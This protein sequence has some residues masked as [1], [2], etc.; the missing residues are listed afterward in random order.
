MTMPFYNSDL[1]FQ[2]KTGFHIEAVAP[3]VLFV[4]NEH[5][6][7]I[8]TD[9]AMATV[10]PQV[11]GQRSIKE[12]I[13]A[14]MH[15]LTAEE[16]SISLQELFNN[17]IIH[18][19]HFINEQEKSAH[20]FWA[21]A[22]VKGASALDNLSVKNVSVQ[23]IGGL[24]TEQIIKSLAASG[25]KVADTAR[26]KIIVTDDYLRAELEPIASQAAAEGVALLLVKPVGL[27]PTIGPIIH[28]QYGSCL[29]CVQFGIRINHPVEHWLSR[30]QNTS[31]FH[32]PLAIERASEQAVYGLVSA[33]IASLFASQ[34]DRI[35]LKNGMLK[36]DLKSLQSNRYAVVKRPQ[37]PTC[38]DADLMK[39]QAHCPPQL[40]SVPNLHINDGGYRKLTP[41]QT[42]E[43]FKHLINPVCGPIA[44][45]HPMPRR[46][47]GM[48]KVYVA[49]YM[50]CPQDIPR[51][52][53]FDKICAGKGQTDEQARASA[54]CEALE[55]FSGVYQGD[56]ACVRASA[57]ELHAQNKPLFDFNKLQHFSQFQFAQREHINQ[58]THDRRRQVPKQQIIEDKID[59]T[60]AWSLV[61]GKKHY[62]PLNYCYAEAPLS[63]GIEYGI[64]N[65]NGAAAGNCLEE[66]ILQGFLELVER[67][68]TA[69]W[70]Y[71]RI[72]LPGIDLASFNDPYFERLIREYASLGWNCWVLDLTHD[73]GINVCAA[74]AHQA[75]ENRW[76][77]GFGC[78][79]N[80]H[81]AVQRAITEVNQLFEPDGTSPA[82]WDPKKLNDTE[83]L[84]PSNIK[85]LRP[86]NEMSSIGGVDLQSDIAHCTALIH[87]LDMDILMVN[88]TRPDI[89]LSVVQI[90]VPPLRHFWPRLGE[91]RLYS[92]PVKLGWLEEA[93][94]EAALNPT[95]L[96]L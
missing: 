36:L 88:K 24:N 64:H 2:V 73:L 51:S 56:E 54:L 92:V 47:L 14:L 4:I 32:L 60:P 33:C 10:A 16:I 37:C 94:P 46:H 82:P 40:Q 44:Y 50:V 76:A 21:L 3:D 6:R 48:R 68:A 29:T 8:I 19:A 17:G 38:G 59:W 52:N 91:G 79:L 5:Q 1:I 34:E 12:I 75:E 62:V 70:W 85:K 96:F 7:R 31:I 78:H 18:E 42:F 9:Y 66:A 28:P 65:P 89:E 81:L 61:S 20:A 93:T 43:H 23:S 74:V 49:G 45:L 95:P 87:S 84:F 11:D 22:G 15:T 83:F 67:D 57:A 53:S 25:I 39:K 35:P 90:I 13:H 72:N 77:I 27:S 41:V 26:L 86:M 71:N 63:S 30:T 55:R 69:I 80:A 58:H